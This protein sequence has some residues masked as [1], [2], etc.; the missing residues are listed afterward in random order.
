MRSREPRALG[1]GAVEYRR[2]AHAAGLAFAA[3]SLPYLLFEWHDLRLQLLVAMP[4]GLIALLV[5]RWQW[6]RWLLERRKAGEWASRTVVVGARDEVAYVLERLDRAHGLGFHVLGAALRGGGGDE[7][8]R[9]GDRIVPA[10]GAMDDIAELAQRVGADTVVLASNPDDDAAYLQRLSRQLEGTCAELVLYS[11]LV[12]VA[13]P[14]IS[15]RPLEGMPLIQ[16][17]IPD[18]EGG[19]HALKRALDIAVAG[20]ALVPIAL[21]AIPIAIAIRIDSPGPV[22]FRQ[23]RVGRDGQLFDM[24]KFRTMHVD[25]EAQLASLLDRNEGAGPLFKLRDDPRVTRVG[26]FLRRTSLDELPQFWNALRGEMSVV[27]PRP[28]LPS[29]ATSYD[30]TVARR[31]YL[32]PGITGLW[33]ISG[34]SDLSWEESVRLDLRYVE[35]WSVMDDMMIIWHTAKLVLRPRGAY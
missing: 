33:Q 29:E 10:L 12:D 23:Q 32:K 2:V 20:L 5:G 22:L 3:L 35:N 13:G 17:R 25:A 27:G 6:R 7:P 16:V 28:P 9:V 26:G 21:L 1:S 31:L 4:V 34:R 30:G 8:L 14:R 24:L 19:R 18:F 15:Y 11:R